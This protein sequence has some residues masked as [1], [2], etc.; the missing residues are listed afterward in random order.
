MDLTILTDAELK[1]ELQRRNDERPVSAESVAARIGD[2]KSELSDLQDD[3]AYLASRYTVLDKALAA[4]VVQD[5]TEHHCVKPGC[6]GKWVGGR[7]GK[8]YCS[9]RCVDADKQQRYRD[10]QKEGAR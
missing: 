5:M 6:S 2:L 9:R 1:A 4:V 10:A 3:L 7:A 8:K